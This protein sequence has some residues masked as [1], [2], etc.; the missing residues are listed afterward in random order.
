MRYLII[1][2][3][4]FLHSVFSHEYEKEGLKI[5]HPIIKV[6]SAKAK[7]GAGYF[8][9]TNNTTKSFIL[10]NISSQIAKK[11]EIHEVILNNDIYKMRPVSNGVEI[12]PGK[13]LEFKSKSY[14]IMFFNI[15]KPL[16]NEEMLNA[17]F[18]FNDGLELP[19]K[20]KVVLDNH[21]HKNN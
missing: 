13:V 8:K 18:L 4:F 2:I 1:I 7:V 9:I 16:V 10:E 11:Q 19:V 6:N 17:K 21:I 12:K 14:H 3:Y 15:L 20:F 5:F